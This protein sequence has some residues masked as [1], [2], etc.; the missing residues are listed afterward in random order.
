[1]LCLLN[2]LY[3]SC[4]Y[5]FYFSICKYIMMKQFIN[6]KYVSNNVEDENYSVQTLG[7]YIKRMKKKKHE[8]SGYNRQ[9]NFRSSNREMY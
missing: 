3:E 4:K 2:I 5:M 9:I 1:M 7:S 6:T 8:T